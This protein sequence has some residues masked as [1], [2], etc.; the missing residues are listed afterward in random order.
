MLVAAILSKNG[1]ECIIFVLYSGLLEGCSNDPG[2][3]RVLLLK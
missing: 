2:G 1:E 3:K